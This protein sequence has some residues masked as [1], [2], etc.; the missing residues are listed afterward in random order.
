MPIFCELDHLRVA[1]LI[2]DLV[3]YPI[4]VRIMLGGV[5]VEYDV[6]DLVLVAQD[7]IQLAADFVHHSDEQRQYNPVRWVRYL[8]KRIQDFVF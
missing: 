1:D 5:T 6:F 8:S 3:R 2:G 7:T 4:V